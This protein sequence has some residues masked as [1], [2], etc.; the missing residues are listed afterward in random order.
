M[1]EPDVIVTSSFLRNPWVISLRQPQGYRIDLTSA[2]SIIMSQVSLPDTMPSGWYVLAFHHSLTKLCTLLALSM[3]PASFMGKVTF[4]ALLGV[5]KSRTDLAASCPALSL[6]KQ[7]QTLS[8][9]SNHSRF[10]LMSFDA[11]LAPLLME[12]TGHFPSNIS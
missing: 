6:S 2:C 5:N 12:T 4:L 11:P 8:K 9:D 10:S 1:P 3:S 7:I